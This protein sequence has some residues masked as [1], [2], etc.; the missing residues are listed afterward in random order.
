LHDRVAPLPE[1]PA[2]VEVATFGHLLDGEIELVARDEVDGPRGVQRSVRLDRG[3]GPDH[4]DLRL[5]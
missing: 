1:S 5:V 2:A 3:L 4:A